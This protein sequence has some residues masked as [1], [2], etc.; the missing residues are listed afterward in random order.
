M[1]WEEIHCPE[2]YTTGA[3]EAMHLIEQI[4]MKVDR[5]Y[6]EVFRVVRDA[7]YHHP[8]TTE[9]L[10]RAVLGALHQGMEWP[11]VVDIV[12]KL[13]DVGIPPARMCFNLEAKR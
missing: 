10:A 11:D 4:A 3:M 6:E 2:L 13:A 7:S 8:I 12:T 5:P 1:S 9:D